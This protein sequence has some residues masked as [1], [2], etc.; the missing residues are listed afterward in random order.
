VFVLVLAGCGTDSTSAGTQPTDTPPPPATATTATSTT[1][2]SG[3]SV[4]IL[5][6]RFSPASLTVKAGSSVTWTNASGGTGHTVTSDTGV[7]DQALDSGQTFTF[8][9]KQAG[10]YKYHCA[11][12]PYM[13]ATIIV[14]A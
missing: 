2:V 10:T 1:P 6:F 4:K 8:T 11:I 9:F 12:H 7:F 5:D 14:T 13:T 3:N